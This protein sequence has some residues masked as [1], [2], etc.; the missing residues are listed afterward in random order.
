MEENRGKWDQSPGSREPWLNAK[1]PVTTPA[2]TTVSSCESINQ[3]TAVSDALSLDDRGLAD[4]KDQG[5][6]HS[7]L[8][9]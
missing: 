5:Q 2:T 9:K 6:G 3:L 8:L 4:A 1:P 7:E